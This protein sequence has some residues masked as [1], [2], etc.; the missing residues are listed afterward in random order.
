[1]V[2]VLKF[3][4]SSVATI[5]KIKDIAMYLQHRVKS[6]EKL[7]VV[8]SAMGKTTNQLIEQAYSISRNPNLRELDQL[9]SIGEQ[10]TIALLSMALIDLGMNAV[11]LTGQQAGIQTRG[12][13]TKSIIQSIDTSR[14]N[15]LLKKCDVICVAGFQ[16]MNEYNDITTLGRGGSDTTAV[17]LSA[18]LNCDCEIYTDVDG[19]YTTD[20]RL[21]QNAKKIDEIS[22]EEMME[23]SS[24]GSKIME[25]RSVE[26]GNKY[27]VTIYVGKT[28]SNQKG[29]Y[30]MKKNDMMEEKVITAVSVLDDTIQVKIECLKKDGDLICEIFK[31]IS[32]YQINIDM[33][34]EVLLENEI[35]I[36]FT[37]LKEDEF[38]LN[39]AIQEIQ[40]K[41]STINIVKTKG[42]S[43]VSLVGIGMKNAIG[44]A[45]T[46]F[47]LLTD[48]NIRLYQ[49]STSEISISYLVE[50]EDTQKLVSKLCQ[51]FDL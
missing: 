20:P 6:G 1:M 24:L 9:I 2:K 18:S 25:V 21:Y 30:I 39:Q 42:L 23:M 19:V 32:S 4:G 17:A 31:I 26:L 29:T 10:Q 34:S 11:S 38:F 49:V 12:K 46:I 33:I 13:Y 5:N 27:G 22:Y 51:Q 41:Y 48:L 14:I 50:K 16:G 35:R 44:I 8:V 7:I 15:E 36:G 28:L 37:C 40:Q 43:K 45:S 47:N 3:G